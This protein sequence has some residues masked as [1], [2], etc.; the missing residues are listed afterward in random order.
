MKPKN[1][2]SARFARPP[3]SRARQRGAISIV[4]AVTLPV[5]FG[6]LAL[7]VDV[8]YALSEKNVIQGVAD[9]AA[10]AATAVKSQS[11]STRKLVEEE[12]YQVAASHGYF[13]KERFGDAKGNVNIAV[14]LYE[15]GIAGSYQ[16]SE[17]A[18]EVAIAKPS[19][20]FFG[21]ALTLVS[22]NVGTRAVADSSFLPCLAALN[23]D[24]GSG[25]TSTTGT[26][27]KKTDSTT[28]TTSGKTG[29][30]VSGSGT[31]LKADCPVVSNRSN[32]DSGI[33]SNGGA[34]LDAKLVLLK[35]GVNAANAAAITG[36]VRPDQPLYVN[37]F[38]YLVREIPTA[39]VAQSTYANQS[40][41]SS[42]TAK[43]VNGAVTL[44]PGY[45]G[46]GLEFKNNYMNSCSGKDVVL[47]SGTYFV[48]GNFLVNLNSEKIIGKEVT[49]VLLGNSDFQ[50]KGGSIELSPQKSGK[51]K[52]ITV[53]GGGDVVTT[54]T[55]SNVTSSSVGLN[56]EG[57][58]VLPTKNFTMNG[59]FAPGDRCFTML[60]WSA[61]LSGMN[62]TNGI[63]GGCPSVNGNPGKVRSAGL[64]Y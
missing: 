2:D 16:L 39:T 32:Y 30:T 64:I 34:L 53:I 38:D 25:G 62:A 48:N 52:G 13:A 5:T 35:G 54:G 28:T 7:A 33:E 19:P 17:Y 36:T 10:R 3:L 18:V 29:I 60:V 43:L 59:G 49:I 24:A 12:A 55:G 63:S 40:L 22:K 45:Y 42:C 15:D 11:T 9:N 21:G 23:P 57:N 8:S 31:T 56:L 14:K 47:T 61:V 1:T 46:S 50:M 41:G 6:V 37:P 26:T 44:Q 4:T 27:G 58:I 51:W 20:Q